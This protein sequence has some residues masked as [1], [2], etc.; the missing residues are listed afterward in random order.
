MTMKFE[1]QYFGVLRAIEEAIHASDEQVPELA[2]F[3]VAK[4][5]DGLIRL[6]TAEERAKR[7]PKLNF[8]S[9]ESNLAERVKQICELHLGRD[10]DV[11]IGAAAITIT[12]MIACLKRIRRSVSQMGGKGRR[13]YLEFLT[14]F[15]NE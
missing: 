1:D 5:L 4:V 2:D 12:E 7:D 14:E 8:S 3:N 10:A 13:S 11:P 9:R 15:F 6:Y